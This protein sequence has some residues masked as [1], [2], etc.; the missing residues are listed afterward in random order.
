ML[1]ELGLEKLGSLAPILMC[2]FLLT[3]YKY[4]PRGKLRCS[5]SSPEAT[6]CRYVHFFVNEFNKHLLNAYSTVGFKD[7]DSLQEGKA[8][9]SS[10]LAWRI[11]IDR[12]AWQA[13]VHGVAKSQ[14]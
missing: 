13:T 12:G 1:V 9:H 7:E 6:L 10:I 8:T 2:L 5:P 11:P 4:L 14:T 3:L